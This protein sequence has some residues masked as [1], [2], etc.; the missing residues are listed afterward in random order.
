MKYIQFVLNNVYLRGTNIDS[1][2][3]K[4]SNLTFETFITYLS[5]EFKMDKYGLFPEIDIKD[6]VNMM[7]TYNSDN[8]ELMKAY[9]VFEIR[10]DY[11]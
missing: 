4:E 9:S 2:Y 11:M 10:I 6:N 7:G 8:T 5:D 1:D 3:Q